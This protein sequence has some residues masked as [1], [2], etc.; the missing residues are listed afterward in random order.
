MTAGNLKPSIPTKKYLDLKGLNE[1]DKSNGC[2]L[3]KI[4]EWLRCMTLG[5]SLNRIRMGR[6]K[7]HAVM[8]SGDRK[9]HHQTSSG[10]LC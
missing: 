9:H 4:K 1:V 5:F 7:D 6:R 10:N 3:N 2:C 8:M